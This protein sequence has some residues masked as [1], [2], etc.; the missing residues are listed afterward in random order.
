MKAKEDKVTVVARQGIDLHILVQHD[1]P[2]A[3]PCGS[4]G[5]SIARVVLEGKGRAEV[6]MAKLKIAMDTQAGVEGILDNFELYDSRTQTPLIWSLIT[7]YL[8]S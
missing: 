8:K 5:P 3:G 2:L 1:G 4:I 7:A 6:S